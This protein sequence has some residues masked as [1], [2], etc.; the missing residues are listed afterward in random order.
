MRPTRLFKWSLVTGGFLLRAAGSWARVSGLLWRRLSAA[1]AGGGRSR[2][3]SNNGGS[4]FKDP[5][6]IPP[7]TKITSFM[8]NRRGSRWQAG[9]AG[10]R[11]KASAACVGAFSGGPHT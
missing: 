10:G 5:F 8:G 4:H 3:A 2:P 9:A 1:S 6:P 11:H 7:L